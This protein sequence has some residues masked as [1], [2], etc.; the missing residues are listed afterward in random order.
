MVFARIFYCNVVCED[1]D[2]PT[3]KCVVKFDKAFDDPEMTVFVVQV[4]HLAFIFIPSRSTCTTVKNFPSSMA[5]FGT[6]CA[7]NESLLSS[8]STDDLL[9]LSAILNTKELNFTKL[10]FRFKFVNKYWQVVK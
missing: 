2:K 4:L 10:R 7:T 3:F 5:D 9:S 6:N 8:T 1:V